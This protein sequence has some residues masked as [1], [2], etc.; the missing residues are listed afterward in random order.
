M[1]K[2]LIVAVE[3]LNTGISQASFRKHREI[4]HFLLVAFCGHGLSRTDFVML[5]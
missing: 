5:L 4:Y 3:S 2:Y 1:L